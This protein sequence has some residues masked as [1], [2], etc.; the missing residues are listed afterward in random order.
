M[1]SHRS[2]SVA[3]A[4]VWGGLALTSCGG[5]SAPLIDNGADASI[6]TAGAG[7]ALP[8]NG[9]SGGSSGAGGTSRANGGSG[10]SSGAGGAGGSVGGAAGY[11]G[12]ID[13]SDGDAATSPPIDGGSDVDAAYCLGIVANYFRPCP[14]DY[15]AARQRGEAC[16]PTEYPYLSAVACDGLYV[17]TMD[18]GT[19]RQACSYDPASGALVGALAVNDVPFDFGTK[20]PTPLPCVPQGAYQ[21]M[22]GRFPSQSCASAVYRP[23]VCSDAGSADAS[24]SGSTSST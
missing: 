13:G 10:G 21:I 15:G 24:R 19:H 6:A 11:D 18:S 2:G 23:P 22:E 14:S 1:R 5:Q 4:A 17:L 20:P 3:F 8:G 9:G 16:R 7:D 12:G